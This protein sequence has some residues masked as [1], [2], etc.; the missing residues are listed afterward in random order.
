MYKID[1]IENNK[2]LSMTA[3][4]MREMSEEKS[5]FFIIEQK[6]PVYPE[7]GIQRQILCDINKYPV[8]TQQNMLQWSVGEIAV[9]PPGK[10]GIGEREATVKP[11]YAGKGF[12]MLK[13]TTDYLI[14]LR[15]ADWIQEQLTVDDMYFVACDDGLKKQLKPKNN[16]SSAVA[17]GRGQNALGVSGKGIVIIKS[18]VPENMLTTIR[19]EKDVLCV[20]EGKLLAWSSQL[21][22]SVDAQ[23][24]GSGKYMYTLRGSG[25]AILLP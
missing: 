4:S 24:D 3:I 25:R 11:I 19:M 1:N 8:A 20:E 14:V 23:E 16:L 17:A 21:I 2:N 7:V 9:I 22:F 10:K 13:P 15:T 18:P 6:T 5:A 12:V